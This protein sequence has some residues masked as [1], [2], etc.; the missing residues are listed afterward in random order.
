MLFSEFLY[1]FG[2]N[3]VEDIPVADTS[4]GVW[5]ENK[6][7]VLIDTTS[8]SVDIFHLIERFIDA[9]HNMIK[10]NSSLDV[11]M[12]DISKEAQEHNLVWPTLIPMKEKQKYCK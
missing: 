2:C 4:L 3:T 8:C 7:V 5:Q 1:L 9:P 12:D 10:D 11:Q 6:S